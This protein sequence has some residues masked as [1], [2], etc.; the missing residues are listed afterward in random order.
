M[1]GYALDG[2][3]WDELAKRNALPDTALDLDHPIWKGAFWAIYPERPGTPGTNEEALGD[4]TLVSVW[5][6]HTAGQLKSFVQG[7]GA[8]AGAHAEF[9]STS[10]IVKIPLI[11]NIAGDAIHDHAQRIA[12]ATAAALLDSEE[13]REILGSIPRASRQQ[14]VVIVAHEL[15]WDVIEQLVENKTIP[16]PDALG[17]KE[18]SNSQLQKLIYLRAPKH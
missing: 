10:G 5:T 4:K 17:T 15:I 13:G 11:K 9:S 7:I 12:S 16:A 14:A 18:P 2:L 6:D 3:L 1:F 8:H